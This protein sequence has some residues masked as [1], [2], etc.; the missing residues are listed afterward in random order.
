MNYRNLGLMTAFSFVSMYILMYA[1]VNV[2]GNVY[3]NI[4]QAYMAALMTAPMILIELGIMGAM[5]KN[6]PLN[7]ALV[8]VA[9]AVL[10]LSWLGIRYQTAVGDVQFIKSMIPHHSGAI[11]MCE[12]A[13]LTDAELKQLCGSIVKSQQSEIDEMKA[14]LTRLH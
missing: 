13:S 8:A 11:L 10:V 4:N 3:P 12:E 14:I 1:M 6:T 2:F 7:R 9:V 5:Y